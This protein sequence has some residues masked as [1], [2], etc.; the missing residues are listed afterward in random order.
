MK[1]GHNWEDKPKSH[2]KSSQNTCYPLKVIFIYLYII[3]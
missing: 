2:P 1:K 3:L